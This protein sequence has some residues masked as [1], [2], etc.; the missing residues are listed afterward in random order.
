[1]WL[2]S[3]GCSTAAGPGKKMLW[4]QLTEGR[5]QTTTVSELPWNWQRK[6]HDPLPAYGIHWRSDLSTQLSHRQRLQEFFRESWQDLCDSSPQNIG[7]LSQGRVGVI[8]AS[9]K[10]FTEDVIWNKASTV[11]TF[12]PLLD[13]FQ[14]ISKIK[15]AKISVVSSACASSTAAIKLAQAWLTAKSVDHVLV[16]GADTVG[17]FVLRGFHSL[18][19]LT[20]EAQAKPFDKT[21]SGLQL[22]EGAAVLWLSNSSESD[23]KITGVGLHGEGVAATRPDSKGRSLYHALNEALG[24]NKKPELIVAH[25]TGTVLNDAT[26]DLVFNAL[27]NY[28]TA[29]WIT[30]CKWSIGHTL[31]A[32]SAIDLIAA[33]E[34]LRKQFLFPLAFLETPDPEFKGRYVLPTTPLSLLKT[35]SSALVS[36]LG[37]GGIHAGVVVQMGES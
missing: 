26:E 21:R 34:S 15:P 16:V 27:Y 20:S 28:E 2:V 37:F 33:A 23:L 24:K 14:D 31:G 30:G 1:M 11:N 10:G 32:S 8:L 36:S 4:S 13:D 22:G 18:Q 7:T 6:D 25:G 29:P 19:A 9:T 17:E 35:N 5:A 3:Y 12:D